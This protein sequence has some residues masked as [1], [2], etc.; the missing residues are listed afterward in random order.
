MRYSLFLLTFLV[1][2][3]TSVV[4][5]NAMKFATIYSAC[6]SKEAI[7]NVAE[8]DKVSDQDATKVLNFEI[9]R[10]NCR[11][12]PFPIAVPLGEL[13]YSYLDSKDR[14]SKVIKSIKDLGEFWFIVL[15]TNIRS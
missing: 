12:L 13:E 8:A 14:S 7:L 2:C 6:K 4:E 15:E 5:N 11:K 3:A 1:G 9:N 10:N